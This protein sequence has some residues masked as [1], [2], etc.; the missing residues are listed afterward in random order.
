M[1][2]CKGVHADVTGTWEALRVGES[3]TAAPTATAPSSTVSTTAAVSTTSATVSFCGLRPSLVDD[4]GAAHYILSVQTGDCLLNF[5][6]IRHF[7]KSE[8]AGLP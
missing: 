4:Y 7:H 1:V 5:G 2:I 3:P 8:P 6:I